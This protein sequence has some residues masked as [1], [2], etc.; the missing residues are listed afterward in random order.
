MDILRN[1]ATY[2]ITSKTIGYGFIPTIENNTNYIIN[3]AR[4]SVNDDWFYGNQKNSIVLYG[5]VLRAIEAIMNH[6]VSYGLIKQDDGTISNNV[7]IEWD[8]PKGRIGIVY[9]PK[10]GVLYGN[11]QKKGSKKLE[12]SPKIGPKSNRQ[13]SDGTEVFIA[14]LCGSLLIDGDYQFNDDLTGFDLARYLNDSILAYNNNFTQDTDIK[15]IYK[16]MT[17]LEIAISNL[18]SIP[19]SLNA[20]TSQPNMLTTRSV[21]AYVPN[22]R[23]N[24]KFEIFVKNQKSQTVQ[25]NKKVA[26]I[27]EYQIENLKLTR[28]QKNLI[29]QNVD[30]KIVS[31]NVL[32]AVQM[33]SIL[34]KK[35]FMFSGPAGTGKTTGAQIIAKLLGLPYRFIT[36]DDGTEKMD[37]ISVMMPKSSERDNIPFSLE[38]LVSS[39]TMDASTVYSE[40]T[41]LPY[42]ESITYEDALSAILETIAEQSNDDK[43]IMVSSELVK[44]IQHPCVVEIQ[45]PAMIAKAGVL[46]ALNALM[47]ENASVTLADGTIVKRDPNAIIVLTTNNDYKGCNDLNESVLSRMDAIFDE[48]GLSSEEM[49][50]RLWNR[51]KTKEL[52]SLFKEIEEE[53]A[54]ETAQK[55]AKAVTTV[56]QYLKD[57]RIRGGVCGYREYENWFDLW[58]LLNNIDEAAEQTIVA[59]SCRKIELQKDV[60][61]AL[62]SAIN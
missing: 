27:K 14:I 57:K 8:S 21:A 51:P 53:Y 22:Y 58:L 49:F 26:E 15:S 33:A 41:G 38:E 54:K 1:A 56:A 42:D 37:L 47:D 17:L 20:S 55:M 32:K 4:I 44:G 7:V 52:L 16:L 19:I 11:M 6:E 13:S 45:E 29:P 61:N 39:L 48:K 34:G 30:E 43:F 35:N 18:S 46:P 3:D 10:N 12:A 28:E 2:S 50:L 59:H 31:A 36:C 25:V 40:I 62:Y 5:P 24:G 23:I 60:R 9:N